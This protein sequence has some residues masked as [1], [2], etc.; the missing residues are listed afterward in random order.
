MTTYIAFIVLKTIQFLQFANIQIARFADIS[1]PHARGFTKTFRYICDVVCREFQKNAWI[2]FR[3][4]F[5]DHDFR[6]PF[7]KRYCKVTG[8]KMN[9][10]VRN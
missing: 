6:K 1:R 3:T 2:T 10:T 4:L 5:T 9:K 8:M 7:R